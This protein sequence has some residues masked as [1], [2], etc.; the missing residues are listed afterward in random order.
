MDK[1][2]MES[3]NMTEQNI[4]RIGELFPNCITEMLDE[5]K[6]TPD[7][8]VYKKAVNFE[9]L[10]Q[11]LSDEVIDGDE[12]YEFTWVGKKSSDCGSQ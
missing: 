12:A 7:N 3:V 5:E 6:S 11:M 9:M 2:K 4:E 10:K 8:K 1:M